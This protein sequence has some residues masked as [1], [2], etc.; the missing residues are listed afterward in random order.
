MSEQ[1]IRRVDMKMLAQAVRDAEFVPDLPPRGTDCL[2]VSVGDGVTMN[3]RLLG[4]GGTT[5]VV[6]LATTLSYPAQLVSVAEDC[7]NTWNR[8][9]LF[10]KAF[11]QF[12]AGDQVAIGADCAWQVESGASLEQLRLLVQCAASSMYQ[13]VRNCREAMETAI[14]M[15]DLDS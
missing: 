13:L 3:L 8:Q 14:Q 9:Q 4:P 10:P 7:V 11:T 5:L 12:Q 2:I 1:I 6:L 15:S